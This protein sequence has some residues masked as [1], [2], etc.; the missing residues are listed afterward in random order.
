[1]NNFQPPFQIDPYARS[2]TQ[3]GLDS[4]NK[5]VS[6]AGDDWVK[7]A[8]LK[9]R[10]D[11]EKTLTDI[12]SAEDARK[13]EA[14]RYEYG[15]PNAAPGQS[16]PADYTQYM[17]APT[18]GPQPQGSVDQGAGV[19]GPQPDGAVNHSAHL[20][21]WLA[22]GKPASYDHPDYGGSGKALGMDGYM[23]DLNRY[24]SK[25]MT[26]RQNFET[27]QTDNDLKR[28][29]TDWYKR[30]YSGAPGGGR[31]GAGAGNIT[32]MSTKDLTTYRNS[33]E[34]D[35]Q[36]EIP[37]TDEYNGKL[38]FMQQVDDELQNRVRINRTPR[39]G[40]APNP[41]AGAPDPGD[42]AAVSYLQE[43]YPQLRNPKP[44]DIAWAKSRMGKRRPGA[45]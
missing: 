2:Y 35:L 37:G 13:A 1:M 28:A 25:R 3:Q 6:S 45:K 20:M 33:I 32:G 10:Q 22:M 26:D 39:P 17:D 44:A 8:D 14:Q 27:H 43:N 7:L 31:G 12:A 41:A 36:Y 23:S 34:K 21:N 16:G 5:T 30:R 29:Q 38:D 42:Q 11:R 19:Q 18:A 9:R 24:G 4:I 15:D 40:A